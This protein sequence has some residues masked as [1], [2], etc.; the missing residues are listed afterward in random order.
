MNLLFL[1]FFVM[2]G[3]FVLPQIKLSSIIQAGIGLQLGLERDTY[4]LWYLLII[5][6]N[7]LWNKLLCGD[8]MRPVFITCFGTKLLHFSIRKPRP[9][10]GFILYFCFSGQ[11][12]YY[13]QY[14]QYHKLPYNML[15][16]RQFHLLN[17][18]TV[19]LQHQHTD[20]RAVLL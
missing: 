9:K 7:L 15:H 12:K 3:K 17:E 13:R 19:F 1:L 20:K 2:C 4:I 18:H 5:I 10:P 16:L 6:N 11:Y 8:K 14:K